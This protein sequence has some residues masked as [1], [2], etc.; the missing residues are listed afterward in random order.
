MRITTG[1]DGA[2][3]ASG[4]NFIASTKF[5]EAHR[6]DVGAMIRETRTQPPS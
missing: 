2:A 4:G 1:Y 6:D 3:A 5:F